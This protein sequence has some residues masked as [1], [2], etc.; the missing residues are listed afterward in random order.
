[1]Y[2]FYEKI[3]IT[4]DSGGN[5]QFELLG[6]VQSIFCCIF[7]QRENILLSLLMK[8]IKFARFANSQKYGKHSAM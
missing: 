4:N 6:F 8:E 1:M 7:N 5:R 3:Q 2:F